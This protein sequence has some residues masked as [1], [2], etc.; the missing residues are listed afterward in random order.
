METERVG[1]DMQAP[2]ACRVATRLGA[3]KGLYI[4]IRAT[5][6]L[7][8]GIVKCVVKVLSG[9]VGIQIHANGVPAIRLLKRGVILIPSASV[10]TAINS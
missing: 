8:N 1:L 7:V 10:Y 9:V 6:E 2:G 3:T 4:P 5:W